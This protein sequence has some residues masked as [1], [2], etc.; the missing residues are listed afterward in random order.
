AAGCA[1]TP[2]PG[3]PE[4]IFVPL[5]RVERDR[6]LV[7]YEGTGSTASVWSAR[8]ARDGTVLGTPGTLFA[9]TPP[10]SAFPLIAT[11]GCSDAVAWTA[12]FPTSPQRAEARLQIVAGAP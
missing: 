4:G 10:Y 11:H 8:I 2:G 3:V 12:A 6:E 7:F 1:S 9:A 5:Y